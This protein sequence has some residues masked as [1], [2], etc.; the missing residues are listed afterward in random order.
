MIFVCVQT[1]KGRKL[2]IVQFTMNTIQMYDAQVGTIKIEDITT[3]DT[4]R[5]VL[6]RIQRNSDGDRKVNLYIT[7]HVY[8]DE[9]G[10]DS[11]TI[12][13]IP[14]GAK[15]MGWLGYFIG[16]NNSLEK[17]CISEIEGYG[18]DTFKSFFRGVSHNKSIK[19]LQIHSGVDLLGGKIFS[20]MSQFFKN[21]T[22]L[23]VI[24]IKNCILEEEEAHLL[25]LAIGSFNSLTEL[26]LIH[27][28]IADEG[29]VDIITALSRHP[30]MKTLNLDGNQL[31]SNG[32]KALS[33][34]RIELSTL[35]ISNNEINDEGIDSLVPALKSSRLETLGLCGNP[36][37]TLKGWQ[38]L[39]TILESPN[40]NLKDLSLVGN[41]VGDDALAAFVDALKNNQAF[42]TLSLGGIASDTI[43][44]GAKRAFSNLLCDTSSINST[45]LSNHTLR[46]VTQLISRA[47]LKPLLD[48][49]MRKNKKEVA[50]IKILLHHNNFD[51]MPFFEWEFKV[52][53]LM[54]DWFE[55]AS[56]IDMNCMP[57]DYEPNIGPRKLSSIYQF[58]RGM[59][60]LYVETRLRQELKEIKAAQKQSEKTIEEEKRRLVSLLERER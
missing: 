21:N 56:A 54:I 17:L 42:T 33:N 34:L 55:R 46:Y 59:P 18:I 58:V 7:S 45:F 15:D 57:R 22:S 6:R 13:Y 20:T 49:N 11:I 43:G 38:Q 40:S 3:V 23:E 30:N 44:G 37:I 1:T 9:E 32:C 27:A 19:E 26:S 2:I 48:L 39:A 60:L 28:N 16:E 5:S 51:M 24:Y 12:D 50:I 41:N 47:P 29:L 10:G 31:Q 53:P 4:N 14:E 8:D 36:A 35:D 52:L 25:A